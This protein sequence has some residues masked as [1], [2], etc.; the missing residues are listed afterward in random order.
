[1]EFLNFIRDD[2]PPEK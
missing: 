1:M 2:L